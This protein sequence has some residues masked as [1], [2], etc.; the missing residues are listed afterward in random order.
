VEQSARQDPFP[1]FRGDENRRERNGNRNPKAD[2]GQSSTPP[3]AIRK[4]N[5]ILRHG[6]ATCGTQSPQ[7]EIGR[8][9]LPLSPIKAAYQRGR[10]RHGGS[11]SNAQPVP[12]RE[13][14]KGKKHHGE[15][16]KAPGHRQKALTDEGPATTQH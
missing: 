11:A 15:N 10:D 13:T 7:K 14:T 6:A 12:F 1:F 9:S 2:T 4:A 3:Q 16:E 8:A 5:Q